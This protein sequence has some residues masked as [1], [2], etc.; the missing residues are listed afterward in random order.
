MRGER[1]PVAKQIES[2]F[3]VGGDWV[4]SKEDVAMV[5]LLKM[6]VSE[7]DQLQH[8]NDTFCDDLDAQ[9]Q[10]ERNTLAESIN[11]WNQSRDMFHE[12]ARMV[13]NAAQSYITQFDKAVTRT[14]D[15]GE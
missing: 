1:N 14:A 7:I 4:Y 13:R 8:V 15:G 5:K 2:T 11:Q 12:E 10:Q 3:K 9:V 6:A